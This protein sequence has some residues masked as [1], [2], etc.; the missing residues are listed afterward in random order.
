MN[1]KFSEFNKQEQDFILLRIGPLRSLSAFYSLSSREAI[2]SFAAN[3]L[4]Y[5]GES[6][7]L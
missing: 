5:K 4:N 1:Y 3:L 7:Y 6:V 2:G